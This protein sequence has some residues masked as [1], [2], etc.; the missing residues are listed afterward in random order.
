MR[1]Y[2][3]IETDK[4]IGIIL[5]YASG[6]EL[7]DHILAH[8]YLK[9]K[10]ACKLFAQ[11]ISGVSYIHQKKIVHRDL[12]LENLLLDRHR[13][14]IIT[15]FGFANRFEHRAD[16][17]MQTSCGSPC[18]AAPELVISEG[19]YVGSAVDIWSC[20]VILYAMLAG[21]LP[22]DDDP[23]NPDG[24]NINLLYRYIVNTPL[25][26]PEYV[27]QE[28]R[29]LL[30]IMLVPDPNQRADLKTIMT[31]H[32][33][34]PYAHLFNRS[35]QDL[36]RLAMEQHQMKRL[37]YQRQMKQQAA[38]AAA[39]QQKMQRSQ[40]ARIEAPQAPSHGRRTRPQHP[41]S[42]MTEEFLYESNPD[43][44]LFASPALPPVKRHPVSVAVG[45]SA[46]AYEDDPFGP[47]PPLP[48]SAVEE[49]VEMTEQ[50]RA[51]QDSTPSRSSKKQAPPTA[52]QP[53]KAGSERRNRQRHTIQLE[54]GGDQD[55]N[56]PVHPTKSRQKS[57]SR[58]KTSH[59]EEPQFHPQ[60]Q[61]VPAKAADVEEVA[62]VTVSDPVIPDESQLGPIFVPKSDVTPKASKPLPQPPMPLENGPS[63]I[64]TA[65][66]QQESVTTSES[67]K[68][69]P[70]ELSV[71]PT[72]KGDFPP[73]S[74]EAKDTSTSGSLKSN[75]GSSKS[76]HRRGM[77]VD[78]IVGKFW[79]STQS[80]TESNMTG[81]K[82]RRPS[83]AGVVPVGT[84]RAPSE[85]SSR[86]SA[87]DTTPSATPAS[88]IN[89]KVSSYSGTAKKEEKKSRR[90][91]L[92]VMVEP[93]SKRISQRG[94]SRAAPAEE[95]HVQANGRTKEK[96]VIAP[97]AVP[98]KTNGKVE[99][100]VPETPRFSRADRHAHASAIPAST[101]KASRVMQWFRQRSKS[102]AASPS[103]EY[104]DRAP[105]PTADNQR[106]TVVSS[107]SEPLAPE[108][109]VDTPQTPAASRKFAPPLVGRSA[110]THVTETTVSAT[111]QH[112]SFVP[113][114]MKRLSNM[115]SSPQPNRLG[116]NKNAIRLHHGA[117]DQTTVTSGSPPE[118]MA[119]VTKVLLDMGLELQQE[120]DYKYRC[121]R[122]K[123]KKVVSGAN[124]GVTAFTM[125]GTAASNGVSVRTEIR[126]VA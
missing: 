7:F 84:K 37:A 15:D 109:V 90:N 105:T 74:H 44:S 121:I 76:G 93:L 86:P 46:H 71:A 100:D 92:T 79:G 103:G 96:P 34:K 31:H 49:S 39:E 45:G 30:S 47:P 25:T 23:A 113:R 38:A 19:L 115:V 80:E 58:E 70:P 6:G 26:F 40:S 104:E 29:D 54:Y 98:P 62:V 63:T 2:D 4:Y 42:A 66:S 8:R 124:A 33:L 52:L 118:V 24:D 126:D 53:V 56:R 95:S 97:L 114:T 11:L 122:A 91:T 10:D 5:E 28:A 50:R 88:S 60:E 111:P 27:S 32:W 85:A 68:V 78:K 73:S 106:S 108:V 82:A 65:D 22:F 77:S 48:N 18:Y 117:V 55:E 101:S 43:D 59:R 36:E 119:K 110:S 61:E 1:L 120:T 67:Y 20:G 69:P 41:P 107:A 94:K 87:F 72:S 116:Y 35:V 3:V 9:E 16:D 17:L 12:K 112:H 14:V 13:N 89:S 99:E 81:V 102:R 123:R 75:T 125:V 57:K 51:K 83:D 64:S 21:Y